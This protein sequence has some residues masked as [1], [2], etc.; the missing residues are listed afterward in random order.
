[1]TVV[2]LGG[3]FGFL[4]LIVRRGGETGSF[5]IAAGAKGQRTGTQRFGAGGRMDGFLIHDGPSSVVG[6]ILCFF[7]TPYATWRWE[8]TDAPAYFSGTQTVRIESHRKK[9]FRGRAVLIVEYRTR[10][11]SVDRIK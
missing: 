11:C 9:M 10:D 8:E 4:A 6:K 2:R 7:S 5:V 1:M 3:Y